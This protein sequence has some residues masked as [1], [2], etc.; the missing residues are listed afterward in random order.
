MSPGVRRLGVVIAL[1]GTAILGWLVF[2]HL[3]DREPSSTQ[4]RSPRAA[5]V[6]VA[7][8]E[9][10]PIELRRTFSGALEAHA[11]FV[12]APKVGGRIERLMVNIADQVTRGQVVAEL[13]NDEYVQ[14]VTQ[15][16]A[17]LEVARANHAE[18]VSELEIAERDL[19]RAEKLRERG[20]TSEAQYDAV[21]ANQLAK[22]VQLEAARARVSRARSALESANIQLGYTA[23]SADWSGG[24]DQRVV[25]ERYVDEGDTVSANTELLLIVELQPITAVIYVTERDYAR[26]QPG[27]DVTLGTDAYPGETFRG[28]IE[29]IAPVFR[30]ETRQARVELTIDNPRRRLKPGMFIRADIV[31]EQ[32]DDA[33]IVPEDALVRRGDVT[34]VFVVA[35]SGRSVSWLPVRVGIREGDRVQLSS[36]AAD[37]E[38]AGRVVTLGQQLIDDGSPIVIPETGRRGE[39]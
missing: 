32:L 25:A 26:L 28:R 6:E 5:P 30:Q 34:G 33:T 8:V 27:Q 22:K 4:G 37:R 21:K 20:V 39:R 19:A 1:A 9:R 17:D 12:V 2:G 38:L 24:E 13:D 16:R 31:L 3:R 11:E 35:D 15:A 18:A 23:I 29:R 10:G 7:S 14:A 36:E